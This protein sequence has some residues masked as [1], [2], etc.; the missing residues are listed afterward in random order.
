MMARTTDAPC[1]SMTNSAGENCTH[2]EAERGSVP[3]LPST[4][5]LVRSSYQ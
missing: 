5:A 1:G 4:R 3:G 2:G